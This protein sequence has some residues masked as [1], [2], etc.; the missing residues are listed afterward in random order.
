MIIYGYPQSGHTNKCNLDVSE[1]VMGCVTG[2]QRGQ[3]FICTYI[4]MADSIVHTSTCTYGFRFIRKPYI[5]HF[6]I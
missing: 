5:C 4:N 1:S 2:I 3:S 6:Q